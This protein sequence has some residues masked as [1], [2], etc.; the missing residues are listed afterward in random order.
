MRRSA[1]PAR[2]AHAGPCTRLRRAA[3]WR[4]RWSSPSRGSLV[5]PQKVRAPSFFDSHQPLKIGSSL[6]LDGA[7]GE[8]S[9]AGRASPSHSTVSTS[10]RRLGH[11]TGRSGHP[12]ASAV[13]DAG[14]KPSRLP[15]RHAAKLVR[16]GV[17]TWLR[18]TR[19]YRHGPTLLSRGRLT[20]SSYTWIKYGFKYPVAELP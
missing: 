4:Y 1:A 19:P 6:R 8:K 20:Q 11:R 3:K 17:T 7:A 12:R 13:S 9:S 5:H 10:P 18:N 14:D 15:H 16:S 2:V